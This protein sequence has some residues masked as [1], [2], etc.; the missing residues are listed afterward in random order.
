MKVAREGEE[1]GAVGRQKFRKVLRIV[2]YIVHA[3]EHGNLRL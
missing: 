2:L 1:A 3:L